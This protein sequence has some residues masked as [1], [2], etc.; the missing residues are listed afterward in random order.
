MSAKYLFNAMPGI[1]HFP[2]WM[3]KGSDGVMVEK[4]PAIAIDPGQSALIDQ[5]HFD[6]VRDAGGKG[7]PVIIS[8]LDTRHLVYADQ[9][10]DPRVQ[11]T[12]PAIENVPADLQEPVPDVDRDAKLATTDVDLTADDGPAES[13]RSRKNSKA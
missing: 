2:A 13:T 1:F 8:L 11:L 3:V 10:G 6:A 4:V 7:N 5:E 12:K 9:P